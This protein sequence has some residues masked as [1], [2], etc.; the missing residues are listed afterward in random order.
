M[1]NAPE[2]GLVGSAVALDTTTYEFKIKNKSKSANKVCIYELLYV[3]HTLGDLVRFCL[4]IHPSVT[5]LPGCTWIPDQ[6]A[7]NNGG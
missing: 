3:L 7:G 6:N 2:N 4:V 5:N 1:E